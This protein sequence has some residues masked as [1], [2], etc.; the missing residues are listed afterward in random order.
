MGKKKGK[1]NSQLQAAGF[2]AGRHFW[3]FAVIGIGVF[4]AYSNSLNGTWALDDIVANKPV[5]FNDI[6]D[7]A[8]PRRIAYLTFFLNQLIAPFNPLSFRLFNVFLHAINASLVYILTYKTVLLALRKP[9]IADMEKAAEEASPAPA[10][11]A[12][13]PAFLGS[14]IFALHPLNINAVAYIVQRMTLLAAFFGLLSL[15]FYIFASEAKGLKAFSLYML[16]AVSFILAVFS[17]ENAVVAAP[18]IFLYDHVFLS[19]LRPRRFTIKTGIAGLIVFFGVGIASY[20]LGFHKTFLEVARLFLSPN[21]PMTGKVWMAVD[22]YWTP[23]QHILTEFRVVSRYIFLIFVPL[24]HFLVFDLW[25][26]QVSEGIIQPAATIFSMLFVLS[27][28]V[29]SLWKMKRFPLLCFGVLWYL[30]SISLESFF[31]LGA[32]LYFEHRNYLPLAGLI[33]GVAGQAVVALKGRL[34]ERAAWTAA[35]VFFV[36]LGSLTFARNFV[37]KDSITLWGDSL[38]KNPSNIRAMMSLGNA[39]LKLSDMGNAEK[40]YKEAL[41]LSGKEKR[42]HFLYD[43][44]YSLGMTYL[45][46][47]KLRLAKDLI[48]KFDYIIESDRTKILKGYYNA[49]NNDVDGA[50]RE[51]SEVVN[52]A[53]GLDRVVVLTLMG[54][55]Y[56]EKGMLDLAVERY[57]SAIAQ[58]NSFSAA[59]YGMG[60]AY[61]GKRNVALA[62]EYI[63]KA[64]YLDP[65]NVLAL[66]DKADIM[67]I[68]RA[69][70]DDAMIYARRAVSG[71]PSVYQPYLTLANI[72]IVA[73]KSAEAEDYY[74]KAMEHG[75]RDYLILFSKARA[76]YLRGDNENAG[77]YLAEL[78]KRRDLPERIRNSIK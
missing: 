60:M 71:S 26:F 62:S 12:F 14:L 37:W 75:A 30:F 23:L 39:Y 18:L 41:K 73:G 70:I 61:L 43:S 78:R 1:K 7:I 8:G 54:D 22:V 66:S 50:L 17:K 59:Y 38:K 48:D 44:M 53:E 36:L 68:T 65:A 10:G 42:L 13:Y 20:S 2:G 57:M 25:G 3:A 67:L 9:K 69:R 72:L 16:S 77:R 34:K 4:I 11:N 46:E 64:L 49:L 29:F 27:L 6:S 56:R 21:Q 28:I 19:G 24:P 52:K 33:A 47:N 74:K 35:A 32:D 15:L 58:D 45:S 63:D 55:A 40:Y 51:Y 31:A 76:Y 5:S